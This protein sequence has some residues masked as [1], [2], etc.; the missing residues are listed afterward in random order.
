MLG[1]ESNWHMHV[2]GDQEAHFCCNN[3]WAP[4]CTRWIQRG[5]GWLDEV[6]LMAVHL[7]TPVYRWLVKKS[8]KVNFI[9]WINTYMW[10]SVQLGL[11]ITWEKLY[12]FT[13]VSI[14]SNCY[15]LNMSMLL[16][17]CPRCRISYSSLQKMK[18]MNPITLI[19]TIP[20]VWFRDHRDYVLIIVTWWNATMA[21]RVY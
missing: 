15:T 7:S 20:G 11:V 17:V 1:V 18:L 3:S 12:T 19:Y 13:W 21:L 5:L 9:S 8:R 6:Y 4:S 2:W 10:W 16:I 14:N